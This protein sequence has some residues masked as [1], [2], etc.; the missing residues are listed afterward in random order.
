MGRRDQRHDCT[1]LVGAN[2]GERKIHWRSWVAM[3]KSKKEGGLWFSE[4]AVFQLDNAFQHGGES[5]VRAKC[6]LGKGAEKSLRP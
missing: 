3:T 1:I 5:F 4:A 6:S 2:D